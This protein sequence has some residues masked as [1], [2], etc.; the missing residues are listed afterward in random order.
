M[1]NLIVAGWMTLVVVLAS[2]DDPTVGDARLA[3]GALASTVIVL[4][5]SLTTPP[6]EDRKQPLPKVDSTR[7]E[8]GRERQ[9]DA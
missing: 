5:L 8:D 3:N 9:N 1:L 2:K 6:A 7:D 4:V